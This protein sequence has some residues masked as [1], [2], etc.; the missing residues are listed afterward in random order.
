MVHGSTFGGA[1]LTVKADSNSKDGTKCFIHGVPIG[2]QWQDLK[3][4]CSQAGTVAFCAVKGERDNTGQGEGEIRYDD[5]AHA[6]EALSLDGSVLCGA[7]I[8]VQ[9]DSGREDKLR[10]FGLPARCQWQEL[11]DHFATIGQVAFANVKP[12]T[13]FGGGFGGFDMGKGCGGGVGMGEVRFDDPSL[14]HAAVQS[15]DGSDLGGSAIT[16]RIDQTSKDGSKVIVSGIPP[17]V[18]WQRL[19]DHFSSVGQVAYAS[20]KG[21]GK[22]GLAPLGMPQFSPMMKGGPDMGMKGMKGKMMMM[23]NCMMMMKG[24]GKGW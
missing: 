3:D 4:H 18:D 23:M 17:G 13:G 9:A 6:V 2:T 24:K 19:K 20:V 1:Q 22:G 14:V 8:K 7:V 16:V 11:K 5:P 15:L 10:I 12:P 21:G